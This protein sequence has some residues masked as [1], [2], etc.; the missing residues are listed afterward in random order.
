MFAVLDEA[1]LGELEGRDGELCEEVPV[2]LE[3]LVVGKQGGLWMRNSAYLRL[4]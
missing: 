1:D 3:G 4:V 2:T